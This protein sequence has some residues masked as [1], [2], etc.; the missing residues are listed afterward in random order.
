MNQNSATEKK[1]WEC[2]WSFQG[3]FL[4]LGIFPSYAAFFFLM[5]EF[6]SVIWIPVYPVPQFLQ[7]AHQVY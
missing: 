4:P 1:Q 7:T 3:K 6:P 2:F 5:S